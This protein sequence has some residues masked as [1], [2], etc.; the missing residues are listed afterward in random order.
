MK[1]N[2][3]LPI[4]RTVELIGLLNEPFWQQAENLIP[5]QWMSNNFQKIKQHTQR[6]VDNINNF[7]NEIRRILS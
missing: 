5:A 1:G 4:D 6:V 3:N 7:K 2:Q